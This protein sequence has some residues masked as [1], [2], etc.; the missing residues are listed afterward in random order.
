VIFRT[1]L[2]DLKKTQFLPLSGFQDPI[3]QFLKPK[4]VNT[5]RPVSKI[6]KTVG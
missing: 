2:D 4:V 1:G 5:G 6:M 3:V